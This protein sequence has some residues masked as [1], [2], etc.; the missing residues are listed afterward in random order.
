VAGLALGFVVVANLAALGP[1]RRARR[2]PTT[3]LLQGE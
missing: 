1:A 3:Q 2:L